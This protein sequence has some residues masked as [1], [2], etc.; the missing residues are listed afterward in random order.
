MIFLLRPCR[1][2]VPC[3][4]S[5]FQKART[6]PRLLENTPQSYG[7]TRTS[8]DLLKYNKMKKEKSERNLDYMLLSRYIQD[9]RFYLGYGNRDA[10]YALYYKDEKKQIENM[11]RA[12]DILR[13]KPLWTDMKA[14]CGYA[15]EMG[16][17]IPNERLLIIKDI[18]VR[19]LQRIIYR[20]KYQ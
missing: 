14:I 12:Y 8:K 2:L 6:A 16:V 19:A 7:T 5:G 11:L 18:I 4:A 17:T 3:F 1:A 13:I 10:S 9:C 15:R 20:K